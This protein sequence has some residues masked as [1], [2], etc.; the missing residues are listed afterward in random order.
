MPTSFSTRSLKKKNIGVLWESGRAMQMESGIIWNTH[1][2]RASCLSEESFK[3]SL[4]DAL[5]KGSAGS[6]DASEGGMELII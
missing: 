3:N 2:M 4:D 5:E 6:N 1:P